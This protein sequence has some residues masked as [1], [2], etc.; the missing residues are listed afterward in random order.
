[1]KSLQ[2]YASNDGDVKKQ[3]TPA[4]PAGKHWNWT[5][6]EIADWLI[7][8]INQGEP[9]VIGI[10]HGFSFPLSYFQRY[11]PTTWDEFLIDFCQH[12]PTYQDNTYVDFIRDENP[13]R[14][15]EPSELRLTEQ[16]TSSAKSVFRFD[17]Q[18]QVAKSTHAG[19]PW[20]HRIRQ[21]CGDRVHFWPFD[22]WHPD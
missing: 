12:W 11:P 16:W 15:G 13:D 4:A 9:V 22:G 19:I 2:V 7:E 1:M 18:G 14:T 5:R 20:L 6:K 17:V 3:T 10:D 21:K 8:Q